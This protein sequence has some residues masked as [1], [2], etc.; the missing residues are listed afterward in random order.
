MSN[1]VQSGT[2]TAK[3]AAATSSAKTFV[4]RSI[5][6]GKSSRS[7]APAAGRKTTTVSRCSVRS[8]LI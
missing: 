7:A 8:A 5:P 3:L 4:W 6:L 2:E 1:R